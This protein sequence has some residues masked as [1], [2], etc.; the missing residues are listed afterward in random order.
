[1]M[2]HAFLSTVGLI[3]DKG[4][5]LYQAIKDG[6]KDIVNE[7]LSGSIVPN[8]SSIISATGKSESP[9]ILACADASS[10]I[11]IKLI[12]FYKKEINLSEVV[13]AFINAIQ[14]GHDEILTTL[15]K[16]YSSRISAN[17]RDSFFTMAMQKNSG[18]RIVTSLIVHFNKEI[19]PGNKAI[20]LN[21]ASER[22]NTAIIQSLLTYCRHDITPNQKGVALTA[23]AEKQNFSSVTIILDLCGNQIG[24]EF[25]G[26]TLTQAAIW[27]SLPT[28]TRLIDRFKDK[29][30]LHFQGAA[31]TYAAENGCEAIVTALLDRC[32]N[33]ISSQDKGFALGEAAEN[34]HGNIVSILLNEC[35]NDISANHKQAAL[36]AAAHKGHVNALNALLANESVLALAT[37]NNNA[38]LRSAH[39]ELNATQEGTEQRARYQVV[40]ERLR[41]IEAVAELERQQANQENLGNIA[42]LAENSMES[43]TKNESA[44]VNHLK[45]HYEPIFKDKSWEVIRVEILSYLEE[46]YV[47]SPAKDGYHRIWVLKSDS[48]IPVDFIPADTIGVHPVGN[49]C[50]LYWKSLDGTLN[51]KMASKSQIGRLFDLSFNE[52][53]REI[54]NDTL[55]QMLLNEYKI[56]E[57]PNQGQ[58]LPLQYK[59]DLNK[60]AVV[61]YH[62]HRVHNAHRY[63]SDRNPWMSPDAQFVHRHQNGDGQA[64]MSTADK[65]LISYFWLAI[66][67]EF[68]ILEE[69]FTVDGNK[70]VFVATIAELN[71]GHNCDERALY[72]DEQAAYQNHIQGLLS[73]R[74][75]NLQ[76]DK[77][78]CSF[79]VTKRVLQS[80]Y[81][82]PYLTAPT[83]RPLSLEIIRERMESLLIQTKVEAAASDNLIDR[84]NK[85]HKKQLTFIRQQISDICYMND[86]GESD[87]VVLN[88]EE[89]NE[90]DSAIKVPDQE[91]INF[92]EGT[93]LWFGKERI[94]QAHHNPKLSSGPGANDF[95]KEHTSY[96]SFI[97]KCAHSPLVAFSE[98]LWKAV[99][100]QLETM[101]PAASIINLYEGARQ[102]KKRKSKDRDYYSKEAQPALKKHK[103]S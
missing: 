27:N 71:R 13:K 88:D 42:N 56:P 28:V 8:Y 45:K 100:S 23:A 80:Q 22:D 29:I 78:S 38:A 90:L 55:I 69:G 20:A 93:K 5:V 48:K 97:E 101:D 7:L 54:Q 67:D 10:D 4:P 102:S 95:F 65:E 36:E 35:A 96:V 25:L 66:T 49:N 79:G 89:M 18:S 15:L 75:D 62:R 64:V 94:E 51:Q 33:E 24:R 2:L 32:G 92:I 58:P 40:I 76:A 82:H 44:L 68:I 73:T 52:P 26:I 61:A 16:E 98:I 83:A 31:L 74:A 70:S 37:S 12:Q 47:R 53:Y 3:Q 50:T 81:G 60:S 1:M 85:L 14:T 21:L 72:P 86:Y 87:K 63:L 17:Y 57:H 59:D 43:L 6:N 84:L 11:L 9:L 91:L 103:P 99:N 46:E 30:D 39:A 34:G 19:N 77:P 41:E